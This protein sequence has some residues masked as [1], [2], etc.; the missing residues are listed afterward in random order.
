MPPTRSSPA[1]RPTPVVAKPLGSLSD[2]FRQIYHARYMPLFRNPYTNRQPDSRP[3]DP[4]PPALNLRDLEC[5]RVLGKGQSQVL[6]VRN[7][8]RTHAMDI[9]ASFALKAIRRKMVRD[10]PISR[11]SKPL[12][13]ACDPF[14]QRRRKRE[15]EEHHSAV[16]LERKALSLLDWSPFVTGLIDCYHDSQAL[17]MALEY[18]P[19]GT[20][21]SI[22]QNC[23]GPLKSDV[24]SFYLANI[25]CAL[26]HIRAQGITHRDIKPANIL[27]GL[28]GYLVLTDFGSAAKHND[29]VTPWKDIGTPYYMA[30][31]MSLDSPYDPQDAPYALDIWATGCVL[32]EMVAGQIAFSESTVIRTYYASLQGVKW[33]SDFRLGQNVKDLTEQMLIVDTPSDRIGVSDIDEIFGH[34]WLEK[35]TKVKVMEKKYFA[36]YRLP[37][38]QEP[39]ETW[40]TTSLP[41]QSHFPGLTI[42]NVPTL[43]AHDDRFPRRPECY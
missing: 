25:L 43:L 42:C 35:L 4:R 20:L 8:R 34:P 37:P 22:L 26:D 23:G 19:G 9:P 14:L 2:P 10:K 6:L 21:R 12:E 32:Y 11:L 33:P 28:D 16:N 13:D 38:Y 29:S 15:I 40:H 5:Q 17:Y 36:P 3:K 41:K 7:T 18:V 31:E 27:V 39:S 1:H 24:A 30:P